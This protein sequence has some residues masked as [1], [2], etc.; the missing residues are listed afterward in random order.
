MLQKQKNTETPFHVFGKY[1]S[2]ITKI[3]SHHSGRC[4]FHN[5]KF[6]LH[7]LE[8][9]Y[10]HIQDCKN[11]FHIFWTILL[12]YSRFSRSIETNLHDL[13][14]PS[15]PTNSKFWISHILIFTTI[16]FFQK[17]AG[18]FLDLLRYPGVS[19]DRWYWFWGS[20][21]CPKIQ[22]SWTWWV[23]VFSQNQIEKLLVQNEAE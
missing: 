8:R 4:W 6:S 17:R 14:C 23:F 19:K 15:F 18:V 12:P 13:L 20:G 7:V 22:K 21:T 5:T 11:T 2:R 1:W 3:P 16:L 9:Y 10:S